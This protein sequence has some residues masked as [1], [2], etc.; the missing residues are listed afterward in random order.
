MI[1]VVVV[2][3]RVL[4]RDYAGHRAGERARSAYA[5]SRQRQDHVLG[6]RLRLLPRQPEQDDKTR[7]G[8]G[9]GLKSPFGTFY[10]PN[11]SPDP[12]DGIGQWSE[13]DFVT[14]MVKGTSPDGGTIIRRF[15]TPS[16]QRMKLDDCAT[17]SPI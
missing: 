15:R 1:A 16:Y 2:F 6:R 14:A 4:G 5:Q 9:L 8:G 7:L 10:T 12:K 13:A 11:I 17:C 3:W